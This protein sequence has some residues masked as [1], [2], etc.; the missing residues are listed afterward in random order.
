MNL[1]LPVVWALAGAA[2]GLAAWRCAVFLTG[3]RENRIFR[4]PW[5]IALCTLLVAAALC[6]ASRRWSGVSLLLAAVALFFSLLHS[7]TDL[8]DGYIYDRAVIFSLVVALL[9][10]AIG[11]G[12]AGVVGATLGA[13]AGWLPLA[14]VILVSR[15]GMGWGDAHMM[16][17]IGACLGWKLV[18]MGL[19]LGLIIGGVSASVLL[20]ARRIGRRDRVP[21][22]P[23][24]AAGV[25]AALLWGDAL[26]RNFFWMELA[27]F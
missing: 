4:A 16:A 2:E 5:L 17:G 18:L 15:G 20:A 22:A 21:F 11:Q 8:M 19:Y 14:A 9:I 3:K 13:A 26:A 12:E 25:V 23:F 7:L 24:L 6:A 27:R 10:R 1:P